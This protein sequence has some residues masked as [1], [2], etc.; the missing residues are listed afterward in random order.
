MYDGMTRKEVFD[1]FSQV[2]F[3]ADVEG[4]MTLGAFLRDRSASRRY[5][6]IATVLDNTKREREELVAAVEGVHYPFFGISYRID[7]NQFVFDHPQHDHVD[8]SAKA[9]KHS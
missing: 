6:P 2:D 9:I 7:K 4:W 3:Q 8:H 5:V 1:I